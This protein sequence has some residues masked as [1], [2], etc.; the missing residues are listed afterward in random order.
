M[1]FLRMGIL[2]FRSGHIPLLATILGSITYLVG[3]P[4]LDLMELKTIDL[5]FASRGPIIPRSDVVLAAI[6][7]KS[8]KEQGKW[9][10]PRSKIADLVN[11]LNAAGAKTIAFDI[12]FLEP[13][14][15][16][17][18]QTIEKIEHA[19][20]QV[21]V[22]VTWMEDYLRDLK[23]QSDNDQR[24]A[25]AIKNSSA[26]VV[27]GYFFQ[28]DVEAIRDLGK[29]EIQ[30][31][32]EN[33]RGSMYKIVKDTSKNAGNVSLIEAQIPQSNIKT[34][35]EK[36]KY[37]GFFNIIPD[38]DGVV[39][40]MPAVIRF[41]GVLY[42]PLS[43]MAVS[44]YL[45]MPMALEIAE[46]GV[47][48]VKL[49]ETTIPTDELGEIV[50]NYRGPPKTFP[51]ISVT[52]ILTGQVKG[53]V[54]RDKLVLVGA[55]ATGIYDMRVTP[56]GSVY[57]GLEIHANLVDTVL[58]K[59]FFYQPAWAG[60]FDL[61]VILFAGLFLGFV[62]YRVGAVAGA[63]LAGSVFLSWILLC[64]YFFTNRGWILSIVYPLFTILLVYLC[65]TA[66]KYLV[67]T[68]QKRFI[69]SAFSTYLAPSVVKQLIEAPEKL[70]LGGEQR[71]ITAFFS[72]VQGFTGIAEGLLPTELV[73]LLNEFLSEMT[74]V[75][76]GYEGTVDK[77]EGDAIIAFF[78][79]PN[80]LS[81]H[82]EVA[83]RAC[84]D[85][86]NRLGE[87]RRIWKTQHNPELRM[88]IGL[89]TGPAVVGNMGSRKRMDYTMM[90]DTVNTAARLE[91]VNKVYGT[92]T[93]IS[94]TT[95]D[96]LDSE[97]LTREVDLIRVF[98]KD[99]PVRVYELLGYQEEIENKCKKTLEYY[100]AG[101]RAYREQEWDRAIDLFQEA[102]SLT[103]SD[104]PSRTL[105]NRCKD[106]KNFP[107]RTP[108]DGCY[109]MESK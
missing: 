3:I 41:R 103:S 5:R 9:I 48:A 14:N 38:R 82:A 50:I 24:L 37:A 106:L 68:R 79:A 60:I 46:Y 66:Y 52:D 81:N 104:G 102:L 109:N 25:D 99:E 35:S 70:Q 96:E 23:V 84:I 95:H 51:H 36:A 59:T 7:E 90:G 13:D 87:L 16:E 42:A 17:L 30:A 85:M 27:L 26:K 75:I 20:R 98:G 74:D 56:F 11:K 33:I 100:A 58:A 72:D 97:I 44:A 47:K 34:I 105:L 43:L 29:A 49:R 67:E 39:R 63:V 57:P 73:E 65:T 18:I 86:Q 77:F 32:E 22:P 40:R 92:Y 64:Q 45:D 83:C 89:C 21:P 28:T 108:W 55:T 61:L 101:L 2:K 1:G 69:R 8:L 6:D 19:V 31:H 91:G 93:L 78:G 54:F 15:R 76:L 10:W 4:F 12:G 88:R 94:E 107:P 80:D 53:D 62:M 71:L